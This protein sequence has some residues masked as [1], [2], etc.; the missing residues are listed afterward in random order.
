MGGGGGGGAVAGFSNSF[1]VD[2]SCGT[3][4]FYCFQCLPVKTFKEI[5]QRFVLIVSWSFTDKL[6]ER[7]LG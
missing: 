1:G 2:V 4:R 7:F 5:C 3:Y 6:V